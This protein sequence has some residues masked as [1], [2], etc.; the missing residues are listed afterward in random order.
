MPRT[1]AA[2]A[3]IYR[4]ALHLYPPGFRREF[5]D[6][7]ARDFEEATDEAWSATRSRGVLGLWAHTAADLAATA[8]VQWL[9]SGLPAIALASA[10][11][12][13]LS[14]GAAAQLPRVAVPAPITDAD[15]DLLTVLLL[16]VVV[17]M[18][19]AAV[20]VFNVWFSRSLVRRLPTRPRF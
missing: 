14:V 18:I 8:I 15:R 3:W 5:G 19:V 17:L 6:E 2:A 11:F 9:R 13:L 4:A 12:A 7:M 16:V 20:L 1:L 10:A